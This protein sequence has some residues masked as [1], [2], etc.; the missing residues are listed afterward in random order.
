MVPVMAAPDSLV[1]TTTHLRPPSKAEWVR[2]VVIAA[3]ILLAM[4][5]KH[6]LR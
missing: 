2:W 3:L 5:A 6:T 1:V 4:L